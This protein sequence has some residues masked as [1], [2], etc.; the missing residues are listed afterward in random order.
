VHHLEAAC[1]VPQ[2]YYQA[3][4]LLPHALRHARRNAEA[5]AALRE[6]A[7][8]ALYP[9][10]PLATLAEWTWRDG[11]RAAALVELAGA[12]AAAPRHRRGRLR[13]RRATWLLALDDVAG[14][15]AEL[16]VAIDEDPEYP[17]PRELLA[18]IDAQGT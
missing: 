12:I 16:V 10:G 8:R 7:A 2:P 3:R 5:R 1:A 6:V 4:A 11:D 9:H 15:R 18:R 14:A 17:G 13:T